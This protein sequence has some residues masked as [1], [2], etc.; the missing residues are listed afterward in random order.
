MYGT[1]N[2]GSVFDQYK[3]KSIQIKKGG[4]IGFG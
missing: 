2:G 4:E 1:Y 3:N